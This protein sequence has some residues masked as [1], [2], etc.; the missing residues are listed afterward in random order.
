MPSEAPSPGHDR[1]ETASTSGDAGTLDFLNRLT[2][3]ILGISDPEQIIAISQRMLGEHMDVSR[4]LVGEAMEDGER[5]NVHH[6]WAKPGMP[7]AKGIHLLRDYGEELAKDYRA[8]RMHIR[9]DAAQ[10]NPPGPELD[11]L[12]TIGAVAAIDVPVLIEG[13]FRVL[14]VVHQDTPR[15]W[16][17]GE[18]SLV[19]QVADRTA[20]EVRRARALEELRESEVHF[21][22]MADS[23]PQIVW[24]ADSQGIPYWFNR[25]W[26]DYTGL[27]EGHLTAREWHGAFVAEDL[28]PMLRAWDEAQKKGQPSSV[29]VRLLRATDGAIRWHLARANPVPGSDG[30]VVRWFG[31]LT[32]IHDQKLA[33]EAERESEFEAATAL[34][35]ASL[36]RV[37]WDLKTHQVEM[38]ARV[39]EFFGFAPE[40]KVTVQDI[41]QRIDPA[42]RARVEGAAGASAEHGT[43]L[44]IEYG[45]IAPGKERRLISSISQ[46]AAGADGKPARVYGVLGDV[47]ARRRAEAERE[48]FVRAIETEKANLA[49]IIERAPAFI[50]VLRGPDHVL[51][52]ANEKYSELIGRPATPGKPI[53][54]ILPEVEGQ[55]FFKM[56]DS[57]YLT[58]E[59]IGGT[60]V[61]AVLG[62]DD[63]SRRTRYIS[64]NYQALLDPDKKPTGVF[65]HGVDV[66]ESVLAREAVE[67]SERRRRMALEAAQIGSFN[68]N[69][70]TQE[71]VTNERFRQLIGFTGDQLRFE[72]GLATVHPDD[73]G[74]VVEAI[75]AATR[76]IDPVPYAAEY[77]VI[78]PDGSVH[79]MAARGGVTFGEGPQGR[80]PVSFDGTMGDI[81]QRKLSEEE[82]QFQ[83]HL[84]ELIFRES[85]AEMALWKGDDLI[86]DRVN[87][88]YQALFGD[89]QL[90]GLPILEAIPELTGQGFDDKLR[91][92]ML[93]GTPII[94]REVLARIARA[95]GAPPE[96]RYFDF[97]YLQVRDPEGKPYGVYDH[98]VD[99]TDRVRS[100]QALERSEEQ[101]RAALAD[102][103]SL[104][105]AERAARGEAEIAGRMKDEFLATLSHELRTPLN[106]IVGWTQLLQMMPDQT[107]LAEGLAIISRNAK[108]Q[109][110]IIE[111]IL[112]MSRIV[113]GK[114]RLDVQS[115][116]LES[117]VRAGV[118]TVQQA[119]DAKGV[120]LQVIVDPAA[121]AMFGDPHRLH[122]V[123]WNLLSNAVKFTPKEGRIQV[124][125]KRINSHVEVSVMDTGAGIEPAFLPHVFDRFRQADASITRHYG[126]LGLGLAIVKQIVELHGGSVKAYSP[127]KGEGS[128][129]TV[130]LPVAIHHPASIHADTT[131]VHPR[132]TAEDGPPTPLIPGQ[133]DGISIVALDDEVDAVTFVERLLVGCGATV[134]TATSTAQAYELVKRHLPDV[135]VSD[136][137]MPGEDGYSFMRRVREL[138]PAEGGRARA[139][140]VTA[141]AR[142]IDR[143]RAL[144]S[145]FQM[146]IAKPVDPAELIASVAALAAKV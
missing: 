136:I 96:D 18:I 101:L 33:A 91:K 21:R 9:R 35:M 32:D 57:V 40:E 87:P 51:E 122:Q 106:A 143:V 63:S 110:Q 58:G 100:R 97:T 39:R 102:R 127:G 107:R 109:T 31:T 81:T 29:E 142:S 131:R 84:L 146:H 20:A 49:A 95:D 60:E 112:D 38:D 11:A 42:D 115:I 26:H 61:P 23:M 4:V 93:T 138:P 132:T 133:L 103:Q 92:V 98:S 25:R 15:D 1:P 47:T 90:I 68:I 119:A 3:S 5:V 62:P 48:A 6:T 10:E 7:D 66:T 17:D 141:Y 54:E 99:V 45:V 78:H 13:V 118:E 139:L 69:L 140:A 52:M 27:P 14:V 88:L 135:I 30:K 117:L 82:L 116:E 37:D 111:D 24:A 12:R 137:G 36:G 134:H 120:R 46:V 22:Q 125:L 56:L 70:L 34:R 2:N 50:C 80:Q 77:R 41:F 67:T 104:L 123:F 73:I 145:G 8:G 44:E 65:V 128:T 114:L 126:G 108:A 76:P 105:D 144:E 19:R 124:T 130:S 64:F 43:L 72:D 59:S 16:T 113:S 53:R 74:R 71:V 75:N 55:G 89:R 79:W 94:G 28:P 83:R 86:F 121:H 129:F 85:P